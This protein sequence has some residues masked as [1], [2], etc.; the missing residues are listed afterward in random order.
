MRQA[1][2]LR[3][4]EEILAHLGSRFV[5]YN[6]PTRINAP[7][8]MLEGLAQGLFR[9]PKMAI[10]IEVKDREAMAKALESLVER[11]NRSLAGL[12]RQSEPDRHWR[13]PAAQESR[14]RLRL[15]PDRR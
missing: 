9:V 1:T 7:A 4:R 6:V 12:P 14:R 15:P 3:L 11:A 2:G 13:D 5:Y 8:H 10:V